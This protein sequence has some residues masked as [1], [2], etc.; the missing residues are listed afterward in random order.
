MKG[1][2]TCNK[3]SPDLTEAGEMLLNIEQLQMSTLDCSMKGLNARPQFK[4][5]SENT[6]L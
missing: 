2:I 4:L 1:K 6:C 5:C 3:S